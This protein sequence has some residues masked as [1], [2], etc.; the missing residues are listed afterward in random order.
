MTT[1]TQNIRIWTAS[2]LTTPEPTTPQIKAD[3]AWSARHS[4]PL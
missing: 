3:I 4:A 1:A 2:V